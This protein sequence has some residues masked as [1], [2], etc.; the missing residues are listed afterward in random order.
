MTVS[1]WLHFVRRSD[2]PVS[3]KLLVVEQNGCMHVQVKYNS[4]YFAFTQYNSVYF[5]FGPKPLGLF[6]IESNMPLQ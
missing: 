5:A 1:K 3:Q 6:F 4:V 2:L